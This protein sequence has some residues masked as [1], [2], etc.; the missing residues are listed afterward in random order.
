LRPWLDIFMDAS[1]QGLRGP[2]VLWCIGLHCLHDLGGV[3][4]IGRLST[5]SLLSK[6]FLLISGARPLLSGLTLRSRSPSFNL[7]GVRNI[8]LL[9]AALD[10]DL[11]F[12]HIPGRHNKV[13]D[14]LSRWDAHPEPEPLLASLL[15]SPAVCCP[16]PHACLVLDEDI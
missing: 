8:W 7:A 5:F 3:L 11:D 4:P 13:A 2:L 12:C 9:H 15:P 14:L 10:C 6:F 1:L 16:V